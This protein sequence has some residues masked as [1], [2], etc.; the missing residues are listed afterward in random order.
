MAFDLKKSVQEY[1][2]L[3]VFGTPK[4]DIREREGNAVG[5]L[6]DVLTQSPEVQQAFNQAVCQQTDRV[7]SWLGLLA[8]RSKYKSG[9]PSDS[10]QSTGKLFR[11]SKK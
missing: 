6:S 11:S 4:S 7:F 9:S 3:T 1:T 8:R 2:N 5:I 10:A